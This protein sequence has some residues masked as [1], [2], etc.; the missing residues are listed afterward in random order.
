MALRLSAGLHFETNGRYGFT[1]VFNQE[2]KKGNDVSF[3]LA[4]PIPV[5]FGDDQA[6]SLS[7]G[8]QVGVSF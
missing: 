3:Y 2:I 8:V 1:P 6:A 7:T 5:R 4:L